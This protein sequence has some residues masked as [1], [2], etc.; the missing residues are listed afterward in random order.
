MEDLDLAAGLETVGDPVRTGGS[1]LGVMVKPDIDVTTACPALDLAA[2]DAVTHLAA[3][4]TRHERVWQVTFRNDT[5]TWNTEP[6]TYPDARPCAIGACK[7]NK[8]VMR[9]RS[10]ISFNSLMNVEIWKIVP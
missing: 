9:Q 3:R 1:A 7:N 6:D 2:F 8:A 10:S 4:L 5:G